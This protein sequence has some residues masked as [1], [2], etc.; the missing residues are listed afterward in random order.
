MN[1]HGG[2]NC[3]AT[4]GTIPSNEIFLTVLNKNNLREA[5]FNILWKMGKFKNTKRI[6]TNL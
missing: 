3:Q 2:L 6:C 4:L 5:K 1:F